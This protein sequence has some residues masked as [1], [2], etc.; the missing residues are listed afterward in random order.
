[1][2]FGYLSDFLNGGKQFKMQDAKVFQQKES[3]FIS[4]PSSYFDQRYYTESFGTKPFNL[5]YIGGEGPLNYRSQ[6]NIMFRTTKSLEGS[7]YAIEHR[8]YGLFA[9]NKFSLNMVSVD[10]AVEDLAYFANEMGYNQTWVLIG[11]SYSGTLA[12]DTILKYPH[13]F[14]AALSSSAPLHAQA[15]YPEYDKAV[16]DALVPACKN[17]L[18]NAN[19][20]LDDF[21][22][23][24]KPQFK[25]WKT[26]FTSNYTISDVAFFYVLAD[27]VSFAVQYNSKRLDFLTFLCSPFDNKQLDIN[28][29]K[30][31][32]HYVAFVHRVFRFQSLPDWDMD[33][34]YKNQQMRLWMY[35]SCTSF[36]WFQT[37]PKTDSI[38]SKFIDLQWHLHNICFKFY[39]ELKP[40][41][42][43]K[44]TVPRTKNI[45]ARYAALSPLPRVIYTNGNDD[46]WSVLSLKPKIVDQLVSYGGKCDGHAYVISKGSHC[47]DLQ[48]F[49]VDDSPVQA[50]A[51]LEILKTLLTYVND[52]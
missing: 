37:A 10:E 18:Q 32:E 31:L 5:L 33:N 20:Q 24:D 17:S 42:S 36:G 12:H 29:D 7:F 13:I 40:T 45:N 8:G 26:R 39:P 15:E 4:T 28:S 21:F 38:R 41:D 49:S 27:T 47:N 46:P 1:M 25:Y 19:S 22:E 16:G 23:N 14:K 48:A 44:E 51:K 52:C 3:H 6:D 9:N 50:K 34:L 2:Y 35:Q 30:F 11:G 43:A